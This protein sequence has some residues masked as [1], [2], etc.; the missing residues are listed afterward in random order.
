MPGLQENPVG[1]ELDRRNA[2]NFALLPGVFT[3]REMPQVARVVAATFI[4]RWTGAV[5]HGG[6]VRKHVEKVKIGLARHPSHVD[7]AT[8]TCTAHGP[9]AIDA[10]FSLVG[11][12]SKIFAITDHVATG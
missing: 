1:D 6:S 2:L 11:R 9:H 12:Y 3:P 10:A 4:G 7:S 5:L 8:C